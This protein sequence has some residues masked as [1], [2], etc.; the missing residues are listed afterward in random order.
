[1]KK[2]VSAL[3]AFVIWIVGIPVHTTTVYAYTEEKPFV[4]AQSAVLMDVASER[5]LFGKEAQKPMKVASL[6][7]IMTAILAIEKGKLDELVTISPRAVGIE[8]SSVYLKQ[9]EKVRLRDLLYGLM[10]RSGNDAAVAIAEHIG[11]S[12][13][14]F[15]YLMNEKATYLGLQHTHFMNPHGLDHPDHYST[16]Y[17]LAKLTAYALKNPVFQEIVKTKSITLSSPWETGRQTFFNK[18]KLL[19][20]YPWADGVKTGFTKQAGR[21]L[22]TSAT[23]DGHQLVAVTL[24]DPNDWYDSIKL[25]EY[26]YE[27]YDLVSI[28]KREQLIWQKPDHK[29]GEKEFDLVAGEEFRYPLTAEEKK[30]KRVKIEPLISY[31]LKMIQEENMPVGSARIYLDNQLIGA[32]PLVTKSP[33]RST[34]F[35]KWKEIIFSWLE[36]GEEL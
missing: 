25:F 28:V 22:V 3:L 17:D 1:M 30:E 16:A 14:G 23:K 26:G 19:R 13:E 27:H 35:S 4:S 24:N 33:A 2:M 6:T 21:T 34:F 10:L 36:Q 31:P 29:R 11:G 18:N 7:K 20:M 15:V 9:G 12:V 32:I 8:G 5:V